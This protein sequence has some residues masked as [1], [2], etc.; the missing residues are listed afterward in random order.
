MASQWPC[1]R[2]ILLSVSEP[3]A[4]A[5]LD[6]VFISG[7]HP[8]F[9]FSPCINHPRE[10]IPFRVRV[11]VCPWS[12]PLALYKTHLHLCLRDSVIC[13]PPPPQWWQTR[14]VAA[15]MLSQLQRALPSARVWLA[16]LDLVNHIDFVVPR[17]GGPPFPL[18]LPL[19]SPFPCCFSSVHMVVGFFFPSQ[20][21]RV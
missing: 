10:E 15:R 4:L 18:P 5:S 14:A 3:L 2:A 17:A 16:S 12:R 13:S 21:T 9:F 6:Q 1:V 7:C 11:S 8:S 20:N 19:P